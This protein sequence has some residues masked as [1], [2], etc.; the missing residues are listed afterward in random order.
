MT[1]IISPNI[2]KEKDRID[3]NGNIIDPITKRVI[4]RNQ[5][6]FVPP[7][8]P[9]KDSVEHNTEIA[10]EVVEEPTK[11]DLPKDDVLSIKEQIKQTKANLKM[12][13]SLEK[14]KKA[15]LKKKT[16]LLN[17]LK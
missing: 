8:V 10:P 13:E 7:I 6:D 4:V 14:L 11:I 5:P 9:A 3:I 1:V 2:K 16:G 17:K 15:E 12:L